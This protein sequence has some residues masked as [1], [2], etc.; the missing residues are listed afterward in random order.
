VRCPWCSGVDDKVVDSRA[1]DDGSAIRRRRECLACSRRF[2]SFERIE[3]VALIV[4]KRNDT[5]ESFDR[6]KIFHGLRSA[7]KNLS[8]STEQLDSV[9]N[10]VEEALRLEGP[11]TTSE[12][13]GLAVL[14]RLRA[15]DGVAYLRFASVYKNFTDPA[16]FARE[17][18]LLTKSTAPK[19]RSSS[20][21]VVPEG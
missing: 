8:I 3:D 5:R 21:V 12:R 14:E 17:A 10:E 6:S 16:D 2:T 18:K 1:T 4:V 7:T 9:A 15:I 20:S 13:I 11:E 19:P